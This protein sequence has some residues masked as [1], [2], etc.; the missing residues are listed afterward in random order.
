MVTTVDEIRNTQYLSL[1]TVNLLG[2]K[3]WWVISGYTEQGNY[4]YI[5]SVKNCNLS[6]GMLSNSM[7][8]L[9]GN[10]RMGKTA[11]F[12]AAKRTHTV[13]VHARPS[14]LFAS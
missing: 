14:W 11:D 1:S 2:Q 9:E 5:G 6:G 12:A 4:W 13:P 7:G 10:K 8:A 3:F